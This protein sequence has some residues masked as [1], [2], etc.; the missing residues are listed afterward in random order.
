MYCIDNEFSY[1]TLFIKKQQGLLQNNRFIQYIALILL[2]YIVELL[3]FATV[4]T[5][6]RSLLEILCCIVSGTTLADQGYL[7]PQHYI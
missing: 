3:Y 6:F 7:Y 1:I 5:V 2:P 4:P